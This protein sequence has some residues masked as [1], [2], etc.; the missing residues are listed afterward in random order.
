MDKSWLETTLEEIHKTIPDDALPRNFA[1][2][3]REMNLE[4]LADILWDN[5]RYVACATRPHTDAKTI[6][7][8]K[9]EDVIRACRMLETETLVKKSPK[10]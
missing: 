7:Q 8:L 4:E 9:R 6:V 2:G 1:S 10:Y 5:L 3:P